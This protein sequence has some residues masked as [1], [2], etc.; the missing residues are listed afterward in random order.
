MV[1]FHVELTP[2]NFTRLNH[3]KPLIVASVATHRIRYVLLAY[4]HLVSYERA[5]VMMAFVDN[6][7]VATLMAF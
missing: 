6:M 3:S 5:I 2:F 4:C 7:V 1:K